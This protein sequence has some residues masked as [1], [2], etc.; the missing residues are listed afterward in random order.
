METMI[1]TTAMLENNEALK[2]FF[3]L[4]EQIMNID[5]SLLNDDELP[6]LTGMLQ[7]A[8]TPKLREQAIR[9]LVQS[10]KDDGMSKT[11]VASSFNTLINAFED[12]I[13][14]LK[15]SESK[16]K[17]I[18]SFMDVLKEI[19]AD[20]S[21]RFGVYDITL[22]M[23]LENE[24]TAPTYAHGITDAAADIYAAETITLKAHSL[25]NLIKTGVRIALPE[26]WVAYIVPRSSIGMKTGLRLSN[27]IGVID[28]SYR[29]P[30]G[31]IYDNISDSDYTINAGDR[32]AQLI[33]M[34]VYHFQA[35]VVN[36][37]PSTERGEGGFGS[38]GK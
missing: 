11:E 10:A 22:P 9:T 35:N 30:L 27:S 16:R 17:V 5:D 19:F 25:S 36:A 1:N 29:G 13:D 21:A 38:T 8:F 31:V 4:I 7:G 26:G 33:V 32:I 34:P 20:A 23:T 28:E 18:D 6:V 15:P 2:P 37:L 24:A 3:D 12:Y 14:G